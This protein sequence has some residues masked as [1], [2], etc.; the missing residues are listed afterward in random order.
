MSSK[1]YAA[2][3]PSRVI[4]GIIVR[5]CRTQKG[6]TIR[7]F[8]VSLGVSRTAVQRWEHGDLC[9][10]FAHREAIAALYPALGDPDGRIERRAAYRLA[11]HEAATAYSL[12]YKRRASL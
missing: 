8:A 12:T 5:D 7:D 2:P 1:S 3:S 4:V 10:N 11:I 9:P 6:Q